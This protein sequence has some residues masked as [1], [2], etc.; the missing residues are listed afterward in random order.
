M[1]VLRRRRRWKKRWLRPPPVS[2]TLHGLQVGVRQAGVG[3]QARRGRAGRGE[4]LLQAE[5][6]VE[7]RELRLA[8]GPPGPVPAVEVR[9]LGVDGAAHVVRGAGDG[10]DP[11]GRRPR[12]SAGI[13]SAVSA[14]W[15]RWSTPNCI[16]KP[17]SV[18]RSGIPITPAL[19]TSRSIVSWAARIGS[20]ASRTDAS[21]PRSSATTSSDGVGDGA[22][23]CPRPRRPPSPGCAR[24]SPRARP[25]RPARARSP[26]RGRRSR[27]SRP[28]CGRSGRG[29]QRPSSPLRSPLIEC[30]FSA[31]L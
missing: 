14:K 20:A 10:D 29:C 7:V 31:A 6:E 21:E 17:S 24:P 28:R 30:S 19:L 26:A 25:R 13:S 8:V 15:P 16:S 2:R 12:R 18:R 11:R 27:R 1:P 9:V 3:D 22:R 23:G 5:A 4:A